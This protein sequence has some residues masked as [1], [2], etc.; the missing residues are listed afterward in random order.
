M[1]I[2]RNRGPPRMHH[3]CCADPLLKYYSTN[4]TQLSCD[5]ATSR[6]LA[7]DSAVAGVGG[8]FGTLIYPRLMRNT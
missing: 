4:N 5:R 3:D 6:M 1:A 2:L 8:V 7:M